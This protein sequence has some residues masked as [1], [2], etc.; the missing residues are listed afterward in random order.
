M[1]FIDEA[2]VYL[3][4]GDGGNGVVSF[5]REKFVEFGGPD[6]GNGGKGGDI[7]LRATSKINT[8]IDFRFQ[9]HLKAKRGAPGAGKNKAGLGGEDLI[10]MVPVGTQVW[11]EDAERIMVDMDHDGKEFVIAHGGRGGRGN[12]TFKS[13]TNRAPRQFTNGKE[14][15]ELWVWLKLK[16]ISDV[17][18]IGLPNAGKSTFISKVSAAKPKVANYA[19]T[20]LKPHLGVV[21]YGLQEFVIADIPGLI[22]GA[23]EGLGLGHRFLK[24]IERCKILMHL[25]DI[26]NDVL[27]NF[28]IIEQEL[29]KYSENL[30]NKKRLI[31]LNKTD[32]LPKEEVDAKIEQLQKHIDG[33]NNNNIKN[34]ILLCSAISGENT[35][36]VIKVLLSMLQ[37]EEELLSV[38][39]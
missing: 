14:G 17:G 13:S 32:S 15:D 35:Q 1:Q 30:Q 3:K 7:I 25:I 39:N 23:S 36:N 6:G 19:F 9:Q 37:L 26:N 4:A 28:N 21:N 34:E 12:A 31:V 22:E 18:I 29:S 20:T 24:H 10:L 16:I 11:D 2:K 27:E 5:R 33:L 38:M 8:L